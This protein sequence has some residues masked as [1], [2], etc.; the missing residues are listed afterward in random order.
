M[1]IYAVSGLG[2][3]RRV[4]DYLKLDAELMPIDWIKPNAKE[5]IENYSKRLSVVIDTSADFV[6]LGVSF[7]GLVAIEMSKI[8]NPR[9]TIL[10]STVTTK[11]EL[12]AIYRGAGRTGLLKVLPAKVFNP[13]RRI[14]LFIFGTSKKEL[15]NDILNDTD[16]EFVK[17]AVNEL[18][19]W[20]NQGKLE[21][22]LRIHGTND[23]LIPL[24]A[25][26]ETQLIQNAGH[27]MI[28][29]QAEEIS[30]IINDYMAQSLK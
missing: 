25:K 14:A 23:R 28:V 1:K 3:D 20:R 16:L 19:N 21:K 6:I 8:L 17:W 15:L 18:V 30:E 10:I 9:L 24:K 4:F 27:F 26:G 13:P 5:S 2:A 12:R 22:V 11:N 7:G 29:D